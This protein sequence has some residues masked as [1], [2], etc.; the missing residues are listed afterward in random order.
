MVRVACILEG[1][2]QHLLMGQ[3]WEQRTRVIKGWPSRWGVRLGSLG[4]GRSCVLSWGS[5][6]RSQYKGET[7]SPVVHLTAGMSLCPPTEM[8]EQGV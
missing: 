4:G 1:E 2:A 7:G 5:W 8:S 3:M 6:R